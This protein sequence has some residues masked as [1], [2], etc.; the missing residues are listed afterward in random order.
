MK[1]SCSSPCNSAPA[2]VQLF[3]TNK[4]EYGYN[5]KVH[6]KANLKKEKNTYWVHK[7]RAKGLFSWTLILNW[8]LRNTNTN[9]PDF[10]SK[11]FSF[12]DSLVIGNSWS[13]VPF[14]SIPFDGLQQTFFCRSFPSNSRVV[15]QKKV[16]TNKSS[17]SIYCLACKCMILKLFEV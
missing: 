1:H 4:S 13:T 11:S 7:R 6:S 10:Q 2:T 15:C 12:Y 3:V 14:Y 5:K 8:F 17:L 9:N 16:S